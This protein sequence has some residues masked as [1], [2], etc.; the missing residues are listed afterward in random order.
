MLAL[1]Q[2]T[3]SDQAFTQVVIGNKQM[4]VETQNIPVKQRTK[5]LSRLSILME[6]SKAPKSMGMKRTVKKKTGK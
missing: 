6:G 3:L 1:G 4:L 2:K 5:A